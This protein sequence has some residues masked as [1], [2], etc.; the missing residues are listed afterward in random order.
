MLDLETAMRWVLGIEVLAVHV[1]IRSFFTGA[2]C[3]AA[4]LK[5]SDS[6]LGPL[7]PPVRIAR[8]YE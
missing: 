7:E 5:N 1:V 2:S 4:P 3:L 6:C 8:T